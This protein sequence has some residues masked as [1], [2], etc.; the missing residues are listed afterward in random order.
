MHRSREP[1]AVRSGEAGE[2]NDV[3]NGARDEQSGVRSG[4]QDA[5]N[6]ETRATAPALAPQ[7]PSKKSNR[8]IRAD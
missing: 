7:P 8:F 3:R 4:A 5:K 1:S 2:P 6:D